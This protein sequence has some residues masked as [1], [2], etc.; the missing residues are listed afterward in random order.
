MKIYRLLAGFFAAALA[1]SIATLCAQEV[2]LSST[3]QYYDF[4][5]LDGYAER[6]YLNYRTLSDSEW[7]IT[8]E[9][10]NLWAANNLGTTRPLGDN[11][12]VFTLVEKDGKIT[13]VKVEYPTDYA[14]QM[15]WYSRD[16][17]FLPSW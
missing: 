5:A 3:E 14:G 8:D 17:S 9:T 13:D 7:T 1:A 11:I 15:L 4:L 10:G 16:F 6:P 2:L 12:P